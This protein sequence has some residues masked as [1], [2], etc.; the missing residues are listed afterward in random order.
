M[1]YQLVRPPICNVVAVLA[2]LCAVRRLPFY[3][4]LRTLGLLFLALPQIQ[5]NQILNPVSKLKSDA[6]VLGVHFRLQKL[7]RT[8][9]P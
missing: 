7:F 1:A 5:V 2:D 4:E 9:L 6:L 3:W 8:L